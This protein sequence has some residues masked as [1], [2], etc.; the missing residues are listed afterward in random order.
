ML[1][2]RIEV[3]AKLPTGTGTWPAIWMLGNSIRSGTRWPDCGEL[4]IMENVGFDPDIVHANIHTKAYNHVLGT[5]KGNKIKLEE[6]YNN[7]Y[8]YS[9]EWF[10]DRIEFFVDDKRYFVYE[11]E[12]TGEAVWPFDKPHY[13]ILNLAIGG[14]WGGQIGIDSNIFPQKY[15]IDYVRVYEFVR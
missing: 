10:P 15:M 5:A 6:P 13:L 2:G 12:N 4:D 3:R 14:G 8:T 9:M 7:F 1:Y 11:N